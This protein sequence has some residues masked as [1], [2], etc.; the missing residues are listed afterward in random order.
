MVES[1][2]GLPSGIEKVRSCPL[3]DIAR[4]EPITVAVVIDLK[5]RRI[6][7]SAFP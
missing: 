4:N 5:L 6:G 7:L 3:T 1:G 2:A